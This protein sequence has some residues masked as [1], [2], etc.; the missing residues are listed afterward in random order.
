MGAPVG[1]PEGDFMNPKQ[2]QLFNERKAMVLMMLANNPL[3]LEETGTLVPIKQIEHELRIKGK[4]LYRCL[5]SLE[6]D[7]LLICTHRG[8]QAGINSRRWL[9]TDKAD[10]IL[11]NETNIHKFH[12]M[13]NDYYKTLNENRV[14]SKKIE[15]DNI[16][17]N[18][19]TNKYKNNINHKKNKKIMKFGEIKRTGNDN[20]KYLYMA[21]EQIYRN[22]RLQS[23][24]D[25]IET[26]MKTNNNFSKVKA[27]SN[28]RIENNEFKGRVFNALCFTKSGKKHYM[29][30]DKRLLRADLLKA[31]GLPDYKEVFDIKSQ[32]PRLTYILQNGNYDDV[33]DFYVIDGVERQ[34]VKRLSM[35]AYFDKSKKLGAWHS[36]RWFLNEYFNNNERNDEELREKA[37]EQFSKWFGTIWGHYRKLFI[38]IGNEIFLWTSLWEQLIIKEARERLGAHIVNVYDGFYYNDDLI[39]DELNKIAGETSVDV[40]RYYTEFKFKE[41]AE[42][43]AA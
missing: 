41:T 1:Q 21:Q 32:I 4:T 33:D 28:L 43:K 7:G 36:C 29:A 30:S 27:T 3:D 22:D 25:M 39:R 8:Y 19:I 42:P 5:H 17:Y 2:T 20:L 38:P 23:I 15:D 34:I 31:I 11:T 9:I 37:K 40:R 12:E 14:K 13:I 6:N 16:G 10:E 18:Y 26:L 35:Y 24:I